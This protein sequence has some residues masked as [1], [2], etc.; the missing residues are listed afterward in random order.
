MVSNNNNSQLNNLSQRELE[1][2]SSELTQKNMKKET[3]KGFFGLFKRKNKNKKMAKDNKVEE[4]T[5]Q[6]DETMKDI[7][8]LSEENNKELDN[9]QEQ[10]KQFADKIEQ[11]EKEIEEKNK[12]L[13]KQESNETSEVER[14]MQEYLDSKQY[15]ENSNT[16]VL[17]EFDTKQSFNN[18]SKYKI[19]TFLIKMENKNVGSVLSKI[20]S[21]AEEL[22]EMEQVSHSDLSINDE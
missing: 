8:N 1:N 15:N 3:K 11:L 7:Q 17:E 16:Q 12:K 14:K 22:N 9:V 21:Y 4:T 2:M 18:D 19:A 13:E 20:G 10:L 6:E 5:K